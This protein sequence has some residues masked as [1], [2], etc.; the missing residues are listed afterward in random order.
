MQN[1]KQ[2][3]ITLPSNGTLPL[4]LIICICRFG[5]L[6]FSIDSLDFLTQFSS[7]PI[8]F[9]APDTNSYFFPI[10]DYI[11][12]GIYT[13]EVRMPGYGVVY[14]FFRL[15]FDKMLALNLL[16]IFQI[17]LSALNICILA[18]IAFLLFKDFIVFY[19]TLTLFFFSSFTA[20][21][22]TWLLTESLAV[23]S[24][25]FSIYFFILYFQKYHWSHLLLSGLFFTWLIFLR[26][27]HFPLLLLMTLSIG[28]HLFRVST[29]IFWKKVAHCF[30]FLLPFLI[31]DMYW[32]WHNYITFRDFNPLAKKIELQGFGYHLANFCTSWGGSSIFWE[33]EAEIGWFCYYSDYCIDN[34][35]K[36]PDDIYTSHFNKD[37]LVNIKNTIILANTLPYEQKEQKLIPL[38]KLLDEFA[39]S[40]KEEKPFVYYFKGSFR[41]LKKLIFHSG[42]YYMFNN[43]F[44]KLNSYE[45]FI[46]IFVSGLYWLVFGLGILFCIYIIFYNILK[47]N[48]LF[49]IGI[50]PFYVILIHAV[51]LRVPDPRFLVTAYPMLVLMAAGF[52]HLLGRKFKVWQKQRIYLT[53]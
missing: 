28:I 29:F 33:K 36:I 47:F 35:Q 9:S 39:L 21:Y 37:S 46:K 48:I 18:K 12:K 6:C 31:I 44:S 25:I 53:P 3:L 51:I 27:V 15:F 5:F 19:I 11:E 14:W 22:D 16:I 49:F 4:F 8:F 17:I 20:F 30:I 38:G 43:P 13:S 52:I 23:S 2:L 24:L 40:I 32:T 7:S 50:I 41:M 1:I 10:E 42:S 26:L 34:S 45:K